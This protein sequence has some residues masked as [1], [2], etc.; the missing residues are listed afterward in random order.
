MPSQLPICLILLLACAA[1]AAEGSAH[2]PRYQDPAQWPAALETAKAAYAKEVWDPAPLLRWEGGAW[3]TAD[4]KASEGPDEDTDV[5]F[6]SGAKVDFKEKLSVRHLT[7][8][9]GAKVSFIDLTLGG[10]LWIKKGGSWQRSRGSFGRADKHTYVRTDNDGAQFLMNM[11]YIGK[12]PGYSVE[13]IGRFKVGDEATVASGDMIIAP[14]STFQHTDRREATIYAKGALVLLSAATWESRG[15]LYQGEDLLIGGRLL[16]GTPERPLT[17]DATIG[18]SFKSW[19]AAKGNMATKN[20]KPG[21]VGLL[22]MPKASLTVTSADPAKARLAFR[23]HRHAQVTFPLKGGEPADL[24]AMPH[25]I[26]MRLLG[27]V[28]GDAFLFSDVLKGGIQLPAAGAH[29]A[30]RHVAFGSGNFASGDELFAVSTVAPPP[31][32]ETG[33]RRE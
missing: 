15:N 11:L 3:K 8:E 1:H 25:G 30:W 24:A 18:L 4:G 14:G 7:V 22:L 12:K 16:A 19:H 17:A 33:G 27:E 13:W 21:D 10:N 32:K 31:M 5:I 6:P 28:N 26:C 9:S 23:W 2:E 20:S 29:K